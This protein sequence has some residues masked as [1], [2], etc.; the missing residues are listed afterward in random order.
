MTRLVQTVKKEDL[1]WY[2]NNPWVIGLIIVVSVFV[3]GVTVLNNF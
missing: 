3:F 2:Q 1:K